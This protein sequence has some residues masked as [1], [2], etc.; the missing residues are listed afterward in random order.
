MYPHSFVNYSKLD[1]LLVGV[2]IAYSIEKPSHNENNCLNRC[3][4]TAETLNTDVIVT[5]CY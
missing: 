2:I 4:N 3:S 1:F 5:M